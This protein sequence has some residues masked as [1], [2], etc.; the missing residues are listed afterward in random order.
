LWVVM[1][2]VKRVSWCNKYPSKYVLAVFDNYAVTVMI[3]A[4]WYFGT[5]GPWQNMTAELSTNRCTSSLFF[6]GLSMKMWRKSVC[7]R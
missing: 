7:L 2:I 4:F 6:R 3:G 1:L 5:R